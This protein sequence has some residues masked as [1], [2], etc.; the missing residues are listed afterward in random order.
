MQSKEVHHRRAKPEPKPGQWLKQSDFA[1]IVRLTPLVSI[2][3]ILRSPEGRVLVG[4]RKNEPAKNT[5]FVVGS[6]ITKNET[7]AAAFERIAREEL[8]IQLHISQARFRGAFEH[9]YT[10][11]RFEAGGFGTH[12]IVLA[13]ELRLSLDTAALPAEQHGEYAWRTEAELLASPEVHENTKAYFGRE[14]GVLCGA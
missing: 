11:N 1:D 7:I 12:Y 2:D 4:R 5:F 6:R 9:F 14:C 8:G 13:Y 3:L 10:T